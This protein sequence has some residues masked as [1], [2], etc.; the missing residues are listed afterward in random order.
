MKKGYDKDLILDF[1]TW[2][3]F[4]IYRRSGE[5][6]FRHRCQPQYPDYKTYIII[7]EK[8]ENVLPKGKFLNR[9]ELFDYFLKD[10][11][12]RKNIME[13]FFDD[14]TNVFLSGLVTG[15]IVLLLL[16]LRNSII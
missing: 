7:D 10:T 13:R 15:I 4:P 12:K 5:L 9:E 8:G 1:I 6:S 16:Y 11:N 2:K 14:R 3:D